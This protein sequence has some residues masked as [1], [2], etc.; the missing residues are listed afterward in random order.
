MRSDRVKILKSQKYPLV[1]SLPYFP[2]KKKLHHLGSHT[3][4]RRAL[5]FSY[6]CVAVLR[7]SWLFVFLSTVLADKIAK[8]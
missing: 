6:I 1:N 3:T 4:R 7:A 2:H 8:Y 5:L